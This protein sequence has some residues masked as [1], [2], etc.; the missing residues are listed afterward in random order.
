[1]VSYGGSDGLSQTEARLASLGIGASDMPPAD[2]LAGGPCTSS[3]NSLL[4]RLERLRETNVRSTGINTQVVG[5]SS[6]GTHV[7]SSEPSST[8]LLARFEKLRAP[9]VN[10]VTPVSLQH[11]VVGQQQLRVAPPS[12]PLFNTLCDKC[13]LIYAVLQARKSGI[14]DGVVSDLNSGCEVCAVILQCIELFTF[15]RLSSSI[16][17]PITKDELYQSNY[18]FYVGL[19]IG[20][21]LSFDGGDMAQ[22]LVDEELRHGSTVSFYCP[23]GNLTHRIFSCNVESASVT[24]AARTAMSMGHLPYPA[25]GRSYQLRACSYQSLELDPRMCI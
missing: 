25:R 2:Q 9:V 19:N 1:M 3:G 20:M 7:D 14:I 16:P 11:S 4:T 10:E 13:N 8:S 12:P 18:S 23:P 6:G 15:G 5:I 17:D 21:W 22:P 24:N